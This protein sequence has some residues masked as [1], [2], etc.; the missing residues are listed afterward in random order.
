MS[1][2]HVAFLGLGLMGSGMARNLLG[3]GYPLSV[4]NRSPQKA[5]QL[6]GEGARVCA[7]PRDA[8]EGADVIISMVADDAAS[9][10]V[11]LGEQGA[12]AG[13][14][15]STL[16]IESSTVS[17][18]WVRELA[19]QAADRGLALLDAPVTGSKPQAASGELRF[20]VGGSETALESARPVLAAMSRE[21]VHVGPTGSG[22]LIKLI[23]NFMC[24]VQAASLAEAIAL[25]EKSGLDRDQ[26]LDVLT[27]GAPGSPLVKNLSGRMTAREYSP[28]FV[29]RLLV[30]DL[31]YAQGEGER[32]GVPMK[33]AASARDVFEQGIAAGDGEK[34]M[35]A[36][37]EQFRS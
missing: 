23:N 10:T 6:A 19:R 14:G 35:S 12:L 29:L 20:L 27:G 33:T 21:I 13:A 3:A 1:K 9:R 8:A 7:S 34:D 5:A 37:V 31:T 17:V 2:P 4:Y 36:V 18:T 24:G 16:L 26:A 30:K 22:A 25:V 11:W 15:A 32:L 28:Q